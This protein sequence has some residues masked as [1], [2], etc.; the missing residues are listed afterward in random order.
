MGKK[1]Y[2]KPNKVKL[3]NGEI[4]AFLGTTKFQQM[5]YITFVLWQ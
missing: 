1:I 2:S 5:A 4:H 3:F